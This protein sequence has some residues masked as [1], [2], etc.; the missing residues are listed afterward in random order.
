MFRITIQKATRNTPAPTAIQL[1]QWAKQVLKN[2]LSTAEMT[3]RIVAEKEMIALNSTYR[4][5]NKPTNVLSFPFDMPKE[6]KLDIPLLGDIV[7]C[8]AVVNEEAATQNKTTEAHWAHIVTHGVLHLL[9]Y[10]HEVE[11]DAVRM[12]AE[13][14]KILQRQGFQNPY[15]KE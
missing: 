4:H 6:V 3:I 10:D 7:I 14:I 9:G 8:A 12:E 13:E 5:K 11:A 15:T 1:R 2:K